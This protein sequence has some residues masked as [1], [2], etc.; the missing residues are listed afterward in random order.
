MIDK[1]KKKLDDIFDDYLESYTAA[2]TR[3]EWAGNFRLDTKKEIRKQMLLDVG[4]VIELAKIHGISTNKLKLGKK[5]VKDVKKAQKK[6][7][8]DSILDSVDLDNS[9]VD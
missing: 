5:T 4:A 8:S 7:D 9:T 1:L 2:G 3:Q 6:E